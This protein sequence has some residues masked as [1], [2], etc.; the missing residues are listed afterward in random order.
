MKAFTIELNVLAG[1]HHENV[2]RLLGTALVDNKPA[3][4]IEWMDNGTVASYLKSNPGS[5]RLVLVRQI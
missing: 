1:L 4:V 2:V 3:L 5:S